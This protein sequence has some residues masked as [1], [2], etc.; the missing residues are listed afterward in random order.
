VWVL[1]SVSPLPNGIQCLCIPAHHLI[2]SSWLGCWLRLCLVHVIF[3]FSFSNASGGWVFSASSAAWMEFCDFLLELVQA[4]FQVQYFLE[5]LI[6]CG[7]HS[8]EIVTCSGWQ[9]CV[10]PGECLTWTPLTWACTSANFFHFDFVVHFMILISGASLVTLVI[11][12]LLLI[13]P[14][15][16][17]SDQVAPPG[18]ISSGFSWGYDLHF[19]FIQLSA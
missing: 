11:R 16:L 10:S 2:W 5:S 17:V 3:W 13:F 19:H 15:G 18:S 1:E 9:V 8:S 14:G 4:G 7:S 12:T 6:Y